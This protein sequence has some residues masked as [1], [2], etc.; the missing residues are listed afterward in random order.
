MHE[1]SLRRERA[2][3][4]LGQLG[5]DGFAVRVEAALR[6]SARCIFKRSSTPS[7]FDLS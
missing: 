5:I 4:G 3:G 7:A 1:T 2:P 6:A